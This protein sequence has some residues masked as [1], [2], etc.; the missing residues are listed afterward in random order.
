MGGIG[1]SSLLPLNGAGLW[2]IIYDACADG[3]VGAGCVNGSLVCQKHLARMVDVGLF[4]G[5]L[6][7]VQHV[8][9]VLVGFR[10]TRIRY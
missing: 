1:A 10:E 8:D 2:R 3:R 5:L 6:I 9:Q 4:G 7:G